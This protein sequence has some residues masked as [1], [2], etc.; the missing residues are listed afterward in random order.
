METEEFTTEQLEVEYLH[1]V[2]DVGSENTREKMKAELGRSR[3][4]NH[5]DKENFKKNICQREDCI[6]QSLFSESKRERRFPRCLFVVI[7]AAITFPHDYFM[8]FVSVCSQ[9]S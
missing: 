4:L 1:N 7:I 3:S 2:D 5:S 8:T 6:G 9:P